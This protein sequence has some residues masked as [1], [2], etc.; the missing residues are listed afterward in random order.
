M[1]IGCSEDSDSPSTINPTSGHLVVRLTDAP[2]AYDEINITFTELNVNHENDWYSILLDSAMTVDIL[3][4]N[5]GQSIVLG[6]GDLPP[7]AVKEVRLIIDRAT[8]VVNGTEYPMDIP[9]GAASGL[10]VKVQPELVIEAGAT[11]VLVLDF[12]AQ[13]S[14]VTTGPPHNPKGYK[15]N[16][17]IRAIAEATTGS[18]SGTVTNPDAYAVAVAV[19]S[20]GT[21]I[22]STVADS[23]TGAFMIGF[24]P[25]GTYSVEVE[26]TLGRSSTTA[27]V[28]V[29]VGKNS[30]IGSVTLH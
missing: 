29:E 15:L 14:V 27:G 11:Y 8:I 20:N 2:T 16:P 12:D 21:D 4:W 6:E 13:K 26:D 17:V 24:L 18:I 19:D 23:L 10:K 30:D 5:N 25:A 7:G 3:Q 28:L 22:G 1:V 9:S